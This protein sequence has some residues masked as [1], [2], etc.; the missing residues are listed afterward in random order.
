LLQ[1]FPQAH[2]EVSSPTMF[3]RIMQS[4]LQDSKETKRSIG[5]QKDRNI[6]RVEVNLYFLLLAEFSA[7][8][9]HRRSK[10]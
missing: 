9:S 7:K 6:I 4:F 3:R 2:F 5:G 8:A 10:A 1:A